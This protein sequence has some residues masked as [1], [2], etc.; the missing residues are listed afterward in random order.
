MHYTHTR[1]CQ[2]MH[3][4][5]VKLNVLKSVDKIPHKVE[6]ILVL[7]ISLFFF[8]SFSD[9]M[10]QKFLARKKIRKFIAPRQKELIIEL[11]TLQP[12][13]RRTT[14]KGAGQGCTSLRRK[15]V[16]TSFA[17]LQIR[18]LYLL[19]CCLNLFL[20]KSMMTALAIKACGREYPLN[21]THWWYKWLDAIRHS[22]KKIYDNKHS[23]QS[24]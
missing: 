10:R 24:L 5:W 23:S 13:N 2:G 17:W 16:K 4:F 1:S 20:W 19:A 6:R 18:Y 9:L 12:F 21:F 11:Q 3:S 22:F 15:R 7:K 14:T 8:K